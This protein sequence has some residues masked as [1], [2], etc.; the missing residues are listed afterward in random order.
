[1]SVLALVP[2]TPSSLDQTPGLYPST[3]LYPED[4]LGTFSQIPY[5][6]GLGGSSAAALYPSD[7][8]ARQGLVPRSP[9][10]QTLTV[11]SPGALT[12]IPR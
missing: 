9:G 3:T 8:V 5:I 10:T 1:M 12:L 6:L 11:L 2:F 4:G 7:G